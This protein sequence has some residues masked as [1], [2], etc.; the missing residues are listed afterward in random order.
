MKSMRF[1]GLLAALVAGLALAHAHLEQ[2]VP[3]NGATLQAA[4]HEFRLRFAEPVRLTALSLQ[5]E[6]GEA[7]KLPLPGSNALRE[8]AFPAPAL[9]AGH[10]QLIWRALSDDGHVMPGKLSFTIAAPAH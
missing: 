3:A 2:T 7:Q 8:F 9:T 6:Q 10:Y 5:K 1:P 4:P